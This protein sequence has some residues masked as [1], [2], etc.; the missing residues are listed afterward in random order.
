M[1][2]PIRPVQSSLEGKTDP[3]HHD[4]DIRHIVL[5]EVLVMVLVMIFMMIFVAMVMMVGELG[6]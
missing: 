3:Q 2:S 1:T 6:F 4:D 5:F